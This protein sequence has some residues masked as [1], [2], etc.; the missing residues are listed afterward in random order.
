MALLLLFILREQALK[1]LAL[2]EGYQAQIR[3]EGK[4]LGKR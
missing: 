3:M 4:P 2:G 1:P